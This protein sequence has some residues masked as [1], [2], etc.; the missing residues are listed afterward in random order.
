MAALKLPRGAHVLGNGLGGF[1]A[2]ALAIR[3]GA[4]FGR[5]IVVDALA[6]FPEPGKVPLRNLAASVRER[7]MDAA[8]DTGVARMFPPAYIAAHPEIVEE[9]KRALRQ[10]D[11][12]TFAT[13]CLALTR[14]E[15]AAQLPAIR[16]PA[17][18]LVGALDATTAP[19]LARQ[20]AQGIPGAAFEEIPGCGHCP[21][22]EVP[23]LFVDK[24]RAFLSR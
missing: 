4:T 21:Q 18:I 22:I 12:A 2:I 14:V 9:R 13:L 16:N 8:L 5:L 6:G 10:M 20:L 1:T 19:A 24:V 17:L 11:P 23:E 3:H 7:G 15:F